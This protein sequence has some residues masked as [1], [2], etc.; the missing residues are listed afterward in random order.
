MKQVLKQSDYGK[1]KSI[2]A[3]LSQREEISIQEAMELTNKSRTT[4]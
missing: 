2:I 3:K 4:A 1:L